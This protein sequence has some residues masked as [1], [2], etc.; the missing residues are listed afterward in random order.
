[1][2]DKTVIRFDFCD[3]QNN[4]GH[5]KGYQL[6]AEDDTYIHTY[7]IRFSKKKG[8]SKPITI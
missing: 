4:Q 2:Y 7:F 5:G 1:M 6:M 3:I 8:F